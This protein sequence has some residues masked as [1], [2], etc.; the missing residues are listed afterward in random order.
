MHP[1][2]EPQI[3]SAHKKKTAKKRST[4]KNPVDHKLKQPFAN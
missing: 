3:Y 4:I 2:V 1:Q